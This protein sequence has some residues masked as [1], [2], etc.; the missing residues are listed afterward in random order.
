MKLTINTKN[1][2]LAAKTRSLVLKKFLESIIKHTKGISQ[3]I[4]SPVLKIERLKN[5]SFK[6]SFNMNLPGRKDIFAEETN[7]D[8]TKA[9]TNLRAQVKKQILKAKRKPYS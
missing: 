6:T 4:L 8:L 9:I 7:F 1:F 2:E 3:E 5:S